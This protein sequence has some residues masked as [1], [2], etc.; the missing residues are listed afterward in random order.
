M[1]RT[2]FY[3]W[4]LMS[5]LNHASFASSNENVCDKQKVGC[6][7]KPSTIND[8]WVKIATCVSNGTSSYNCSKINPD[9]LLFCE[10]RRDVPATYYMKRKDVNDSNINEVRKSLETINTDSFECFYAN[11]HCY[12][13]RNYPAFK[14][15]KSC[16]E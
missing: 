6:K 11:P 4:L 5:C 2:F 3:V 10:Q 9:V 7:F 15:P 12:N 1:L 8:D 14:P 16:D 13:P